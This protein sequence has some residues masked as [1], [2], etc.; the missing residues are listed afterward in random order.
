MMLPQWIVDDFVTFVSSA[1]VSLRALAIRYSH[2][3][4]AGR[5]RPKRLQQRQ[6]RKV[7]EM[8]KIMSKNYKI[9]RARFVAE[10][11]KAKAAL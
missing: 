11:A 7:F 9:T 10:S 6:R 5:A 2:H 3:P 8:S 1:N 4:A